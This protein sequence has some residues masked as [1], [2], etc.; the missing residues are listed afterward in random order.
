[1][2][3][4]VQQRG[5]SLPNLWAPRNERCRV[6][7]MQKV[8]V[9]KLEKN[10]WS[11]TGSLKTAIVSPPVKLELR[12]LST[13]AQEQLKKG[14]QVYAFLA[15]RQHEDMC[16]V[17][18]KKGVK[19]IFTPPMDEGVY[20]RDIGIVVGNE[21]YR[22]SMKE[23]LRQPETELIE[24]GT[25]F[26]P[27]G[28]F[29]EGGDVFLYRGEIFVGLGKR[30]NDD[31]VKALQ[32]VL[33]KWRVKPIKLLEDTLHHA[34][35]LDCAFTILG[36]DRALACPEL[37]ANKEDIIYFQRLFRNGVITVS[38]K[39]AKALATNLLHI[40]PETILTITNPHDPERRSFQITTTL[41][42]LYN[43]IEIDYSEMAK[44]IGSVRC[45]ILPIYRE[46]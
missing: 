43:V 28:M 36:D 31:A 40:N 27:K 26:L 10:V 17:L 41:S 21:F 8:L 34:L 30:T 14:G 25:N 4:L 3:A 1:M 13:A 38:E 44:A 20:T 46:G 32:K 39:E 2:N 6:F 37:F 11:E 9:D 18:D 15:A 22:A 16:E 24:G 5:S 19:L 45:S 29:L 12:A 33:P 35:H 23:P 42:K 7:E